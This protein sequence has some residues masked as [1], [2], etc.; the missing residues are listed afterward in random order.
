[1]LF[2]NKQRFIKCSLLHLARYERARVTKTDEKNSYKRLFPRFNKLSERVKKKRVRISVAC[3]K[4]SLCH[5]LFAQ[6]QFLA[7]NSVFC[8]PRRWTF[9]NMIYIGLTFGGDDTAY[10]FNIQP[11]A[12]VSNADIPSVPYV[13]HNK[14][15][16]TQ[17]AM[18][19]QIAVRYQ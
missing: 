10:M 7:G 15:W 16:S 3:H 1:M 12:L 4:L 5:I 17:A 6:R 8:G 2:K 18:Q 14:M 13:H 19:P 11:T 9:K